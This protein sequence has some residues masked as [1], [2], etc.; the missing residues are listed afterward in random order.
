MASVSS[1]GGKRTAW[2]SFLAMTVGAKVT[3]GRVRLMISGAA[4]LPLHVHQFLVAAMGCDVTTQRLE[5]SRLA[6]RAYM[7]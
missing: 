6:S 1:D 3:G 7:C 2:G 5:P 4:P